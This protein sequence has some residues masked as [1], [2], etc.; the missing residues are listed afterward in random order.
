MNSPTL[1]VA[2]EH[3]RQ[4]QREAARATLVRRVGAAARAERGVRR[5][6]LRAER[7]QAALQALPL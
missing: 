7:A 1:Q 5:A 2:L 4:R 3:A 6:V